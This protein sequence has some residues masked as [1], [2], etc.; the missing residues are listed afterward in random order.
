MVMLA[1][2]RRSGG[3]EAV[4]RKLNVQPPVAALAAASLLPFIIGGFR[5]RFEAADGTAAGLAGLQAE[6]D[7]L[8]GGDLAVAVM[9]PQP[10]DQAIG[11]QILRNMVGP[12]DVA[13]AIAE[14]ASRET[15]LDLATIGALLPL[16]TMLVGGYLAARISASDLSGAGI[17]EEISTLLALDCEPNPLDTLGRS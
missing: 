15:G 10:V 4:A 14:Y 6:I 7:Q 8:G 16:L 17:A 3:L 9:M 11:S 13:S 2:L 1:M 5:R 12:D